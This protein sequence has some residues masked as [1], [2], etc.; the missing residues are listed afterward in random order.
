M[1]HLET[2]GTTLGDVMN[3]L[4]SQDKTLL[5]VINHMSHMEQR[6]TARL[7]KHDEMFKVQGK[8]ITNLEIRLTERIDRLS[9]RIQ[10][11]DE[12]LMAT[13]TDTIIIRKHVGMPLPE[14]D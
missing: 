8:Q 3:R 14:E 9:E 2:Q 12:D 7:D 13:I 6:L 5:D 11:L 10:A 4:K 1:T